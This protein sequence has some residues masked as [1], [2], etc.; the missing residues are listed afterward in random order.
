MASPH[1]STLHP[2]CCS[3]SL[4]SHGCL[5]SV[6]L[7]VSLSS[8]SR[9][10]SVPVG[11]VSGSTCCSW[12]PFSLAALSVSPVGGKS[13]FA[14]SPSSWSEVTLDDCPPRDGDRSGG[15]CSGSF[16]YFEG[17]SVG[18]RRRQVNLAST[19]A[20]VRAIKHFTDFSC[21]LSVLDVAERSLGPIC[22]IATKT[23]LPNK[24]TG[25]VFTSVLLARQLIT[26]GKVF[27][28]ASAPTWPW[29]I[30]NNSRIRPRT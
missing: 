17:E 13:S 24:V 11:G 15:G 12:A 18:R 23:A 6:F 4:A 29:I 14:T 10:F 25:T 8:A 1:G 20:V 21:L 19:L 7:C 26:D 22:D 5:R 16:L 3:N 28:L 9:M 30:V 2:L 27:A